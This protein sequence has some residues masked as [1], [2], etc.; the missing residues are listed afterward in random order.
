MFDLIFSTTVVLPSGRCST[1]LTRLPEQTLSSVL[2]KRMALDAAYG[3][4]SQRA[5]TGSSAGRPMTFRY[6]WQSADDGSSAV[7]ATSVMWIKCL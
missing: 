2:R 6:A 1:V 4:K 5:V 7:R 3:G